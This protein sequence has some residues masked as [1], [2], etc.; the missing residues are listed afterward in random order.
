MTKPPKTPRPQKSPILPSSPN[1][2]PDPTIGLVQEKLIGRV[3]VE[4]AKLEGCMVDSILELSGLEFEVGRI[5]T[6]RMDATALIRTLREI[7][8]LK[9]LEHDFHALAQI[10]DKIDIKRDDRNL[11]VHGTWGR[12]VGQNTAFAISLRVKSKPSEVVSETFPHI[13]MKEIISEIQ[14]LKWDLIRLLKLDASTR[15]NPRPPPSS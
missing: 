5:F 10:C 12:T 15:A 13:R 9:L 3:V 6:S 14:S 11:I 2:V 1:D 7:G 4:W 8:Q